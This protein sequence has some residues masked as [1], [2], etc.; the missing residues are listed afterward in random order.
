MI[1]T[2][3]IEEL[4]QIVG[5]DN[6]LTSK[7]DMVAYSY[8]A[9]ALWSNTPDVVVLPENAAQI[10][11]VLK[12]ADDNRIP[13]TPRGSGTNVSGGSIPIKGGIVLCTTR[14]TRILE[15]NPTNLNA[16]VE[17]GVILQDFNA[18][19]AEHGPCAIHRMSFSPIRSGS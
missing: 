4:R 19:L 2:N 9:T 15:I 14:M 10:S 8:D 12:L 5:K 18:A 6:I 11:Q 7:E 3:H 13:V 16:T 1:E 17:P